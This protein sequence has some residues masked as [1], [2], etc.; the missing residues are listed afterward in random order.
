MIRRNELAG[1]DIGNLFSKAGLGLLGETGTRVIFRSNV[2]PD[3]TID[4]SG[5]MKAQAGKKPEPDTEE[6]PVSSSDKKLL[7]IIRPEVTL[8]V[9]GNHASYAPYGRPQRSWAIVFVFA[10]I[11]STLLGAKVAWALCKKI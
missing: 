2:T 11:A 5:L 6:V 8:N 3:I 4:I 9:L 7:K 10:I 1:N